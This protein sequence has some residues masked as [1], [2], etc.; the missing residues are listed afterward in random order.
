MRYSESREQSAE[1]L[2]MVLPHMSRQAA[3]FS[4]V[5]YAVWYEYCAGVNPPL[6]EALDAK[7]A[8]GKPLEDADM[9]GLFEKFVAMRDLQASERVGEHIKDVIA[10][11]NDATTRANS[12]VSQ[13]SRGLSEAQMKLVDQQAPEQIAALVSTLVA[14]TE[15][16]RSQTESLKSNLDTTTINPNTTTTVNTIPS[17]MPHCAT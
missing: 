3:G 1:L 13:Y 9:L 2:R 15:R 17:T 8:A 11:V 10:R 6:K 14:E 5:S 12:E 7:L 4:P 16:V